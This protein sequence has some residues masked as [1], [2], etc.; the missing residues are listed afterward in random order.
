MFKRESG[1]IRQRHRLTSVQIIVIFYISAV[2]ISTILLGL[3]VMHRSGVEL[4]FIDT[5]FTA[6]SAISV[7]GLT[8]VNT[9]ETFSVTGVLVLAVILQFGGIGIMTLGTFIWLVTGK[10][11]GLMDRQLIMVDQNRPTLSGLVILMKNIL[12]IALLIELVGT[13]ILGGYFWFAGYYD[14]WISALYYGFFA[15]LSAFTNAGFDIFGNSLQQFARD[16]VVQVIQMLMIVGGAIGFPVLV[17]VKEYLSKRNPKFKFSL[18]TKLTTFTYLVLAL[19]GF[20]GIAALESGL[21]MAGM[22]WHQ[23]IFVSLFNTVTARSAGLSTMDVA[24]FSEATQL[25][26]SGLMFIG[27]SPSSVGGGIRTTTFIIALLMIY[28]YA[29]GRTEVRVFKRELHADDITKAILVFVVALL[30]TFTSVVVLSATETF[31]L[32]AIT[33]EVSSAFGTTG[34]SM[35]ITSGLTPFGKCLLMIL[36]FVGRIGLLSFLFIIRN[37]RKRKSRFHYPRERIIIG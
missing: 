32:T 20:F 18:F 33:F 22:P 3:P 16:Y 5:L 14:T 23:K 36:M 1:A 8:V 37:D 15:S 2:V 28:S 17:E 35:G 25:F 9:A 21:Y 29:R 19:I 7:T 24:Q 6:V 30:L 13:I 4:S 27:A 31:S 26:L 11:I 10:K 34:L 12:A